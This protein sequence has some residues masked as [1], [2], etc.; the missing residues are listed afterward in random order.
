MLRNVKK[1][2]SDKTIWP[3]FS[4]IQFQFCSHPTSQ[5]AIISHQMTGIA[6]YIHL[7]SIRKIARLMILKARSLKGP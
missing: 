6:I 5:T 2:D 1:I 7:Q 3:L 4:T